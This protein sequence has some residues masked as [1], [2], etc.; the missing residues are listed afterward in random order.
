MYR[1]DTVTQSFMTLRTSK[2]KEDE[3]R[4]PPRVPTY[5]RLS[6]TLTRLD[7]SFISCLSTSSFLAKFTS[8]TTQLSKIG[9]RSD[10]TKNGLTSWAFTRGGRSWSVSI[11]SR[12]ALCRAMRDNAGESKLGGLRIVGRRY[13][14]RRVRKIAEGAGV[15]PEIRLQCLRVK[16]RERETN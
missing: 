7:S 1:D 11:G 10:C 13:N 2:E 4:K 6:V 16:M 12:R 3:R 15:E 9:A 14:L 5:M 8:R